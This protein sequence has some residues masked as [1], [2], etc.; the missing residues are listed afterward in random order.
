MEGS[1]PSCHMELSNRATSFSPLGF[2]RLIRGSCKISFVGIIVRFMKLPLHPRA[3]VRPFL[4]DV[5]HAASLL[6][7][8]ASMDAVRSKGRKRWSL[9]R[10]GGGGEAMD[11]QKDEFTRKITYGKTIATVIKTDS[12]RKKTY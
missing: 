2:C 12:G 3:C 10:K 8:L 7:L 5:I 6:L 9:I 4:H 1:I 11:T